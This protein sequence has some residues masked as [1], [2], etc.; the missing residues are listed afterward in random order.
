VLSVLKGTLAD[1]LLQVWES[2]CCFAPLLQLQQAPSLEQLERGLL[3]VVSHT[4]TMASSILHDASSGSAPAGSSALAAAAAA[5]PVGQEQLDADVAAG[6]AWVQLHTAILDVLVQDVFG[7]VS[8]AVFDVEGMRA[9]S[10]R[11][12]AAATPVVDETTWPEAA[13]RLLAATATAT[14]LAQVRAG[15]AG[16]ARG[17]GGTP[18]Q[19]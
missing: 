10:K 3:G 19:P 12:L 2:A 1:Q 15:W 16:G 8:H 17:G 14:F 9:A 5:A 13:R 18:L 4:G 11:E 6:S 7:A